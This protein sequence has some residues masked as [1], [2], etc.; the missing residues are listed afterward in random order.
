MS[1]PPSE[2]SAKHARKQASNNST[3][4]I[5]CQQDG[6]WC[7]GPRLELLRNLTGVAETAVRGSMLAVELS[8]GIR[9]WQ[10]SSF[11]TVVEGVAVR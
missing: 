9:G 10:F 6:G 11:H 2:A 8:W 1:M 4:C 7:G 3:N 5:L